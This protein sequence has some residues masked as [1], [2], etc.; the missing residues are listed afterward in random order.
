MEDRTETARGGGE[1]RWIVDLMRHREVCRVVG[2]S[3]GG[4]VVTGVRHLSELPTTHSH[5]YMCLIV[6]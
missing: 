2:I 6:N 4:I 5:V 1:G 3:Q